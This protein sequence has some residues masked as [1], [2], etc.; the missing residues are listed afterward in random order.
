MDESSPSRSVLRMSARGDR[1][2]ALS[3]PAHA[4]TT[5]KPEARAAS[6]RGADAA[7][8]RPGRVCRPRWAG[9]PECPA[10]RGS[11]PSGAARPTPVVRARGSV[12]GVL[13]VV[14]GRG[15]GPG[16]RIIVA[17]HL[18]PVA[19]RASNVLWRRVAEARGAVEEAPPR[20]QADEDLTRAPLQ[21]C[22]LHL[23]DGVVARVED[24]QGSGLS[25]FEPVQ[26]SPDLLGGDLVGVLGGSDAPRIHGSGPTLA[27]EVELCDELL[28]VGPACDDGLAGGVAGRMI[29]VA[30]LSGLASAS[31]RGHTLMSTA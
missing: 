9:G 7:R 12:T 13:T 17:L 6:H 26:Q 29:V 23:D 15:L 27:H 5:T 4:T 19:T 24:E 14:L 18:R 31:Q 21:W 2:P 8:P 20:P 1:V 11:G 3:P 10:P 16:A 22:S 30:A 25:S 28:L